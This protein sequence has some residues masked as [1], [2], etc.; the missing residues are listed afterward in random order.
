MQKILDGS[1]ASLAHAFASLARN[2]RRQRRLYLATVVSLMAIVVASALLLALLAANRQLDYRRTLAAQH[3]ADLSLLL[4]REASFLRRTEYTLGF[5]LQTDDVLRLS[6][7]V[8]AS[9]RRSGA[10]RGVVGAE[11]LHFDVLVG[12]ATRA[13]WGPALAAK[14]WRIYEAGQS[15]LVTQ[16]AF[17]LRHRAVLLGLN[18]DYGVILPAAGTPAASASASAS[19]TGTASLPDPA[20]LGILRDSLI[21]QLQT[22]TGRRVPAKGERIWLGP[23]RDPL[24]GKLMMTAV[25]AVYADATPAAPAAPAALIAMS[26]AVDA[27]YAHLARPGSAGTLLLMTT[28][29]RAI[30]ASP[31]T[32]AA[33]ERML[34]D[35]TAS[36][37]GD[38]YRYTRHGVMLLEPLMPGFGWLVGYLPW[39]GLVGV[40]GWQLGALAGV[41]LLMLTAIV[42]TARV[43]GLRLLR[44]SVAETA[45]ALESEALNHILVSATPVGLCIVRQSD[46]ALLIANAL[47]G[48]LLHVSPA[49]AGLPP[50]A[51]PRLSADASSPALNPTSPSL[52]QLP[53]HIVAALRAQPVESHAGSST[54]IAVFVVPARPVPADACSAQF[55]QITYAPARHAGEDVWFCAI[56]DVTAQ[57]ALEQQLRLAQQTSETMLR[58]RS[59]FFASMSH[60]IRTPLN[61]LLGNLELFAR[62]PGL[63]AH[64][65]RLATLGVAADVLRRVVGDI[66]DFS[67]IDAGEMKLVSAPFRVIDDFENLA[68]SYAPLATDRAI[69]FYPHLSPSL[70]QVLCGDRTRIAQIVNNLLGNAFKFTSSG[71]I[72]LHAEIADDLSGRSML[73]CRVSDSG[74]GIDPALVSQVFD[75]FVQGDVNTSSRYGGTGLGLSIC[76][77]LCKLMGGEIAVESALGVGS[78]FSVSIPLAPASGAARMPPVLSTTGG[79]V[80]VLSEDAESGRIM[81]GWLARSGWAV[82]TV[83]SQP[84]AHAWLRANQLDVLVVTGEYDLDAIAALRAIRPVR[85]VWV[86]RTGAHRAAW[87]GDTVLEVS[88]FSHA[89]ILAAVQEAHDGHSES[90][91]VAAPAPAAASSA[92]DPA[93]QGLA[94]LVAEDNPLNQALIAEQLVALGAVPTVVGDGQQ[95]LALI[96]RTSFDVV[97]TDVRMPVMDG[98]RLLAALRARRSDLPVLA[99]SAITDRQPADTWRERGFA[100]YIGKPASLDELAKALSA[101]A[102][103]RAGVAVVPPSPIASGPDDRARYM[104]MLKDHLSA[105]LPRL[106]A[107]VERRDRRALRDWAH[108][109]GGAFL[110][111][112]ETGVA[113]QCREL[114]RLCDAEVR[115]RPGMGKVAMTLHGRLCARFGLDKPL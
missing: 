88:A 15:T 22:Q 52:L 56:L 79:R 78:V 101:V 64:R 90:C 105:D 55:L 36:L 41:A 48:E 108:G 42:V 71:K 113:M 32:D 1:Q 51:Q 23:Y 67:K 110:V 99:F 74:I 92:P 77:R 106:A 97:L 43:W 62:T 85:A 69:R 29:R 100:G 12:A 84:R 18:E 40:L 89:A 63:D 35:A 8:E 24:Q 103:R 94:V 66:L 75:P 25:S 16:Q 80:L 45:R 112:R 31:P 19:A 60:E 27:L 17:E 54:T 111:V 53:P 65:Q 68:L 10:A 93:L 5:Y 76:A 57:H 3:A 26:I 47:A 107:I 7:G 33:T 30:V 95:A 104:A 44:N 38:R 14:L 50:C 86:T 109:A 96:D 11:G 61:A 70:D 20:V 6:D 46:D 49:D 102:T 59:D 4:H 91:A 83:D 82:G 98:D 87:H 13:K 37:S 58:A 34:H 9:I 114:Q 2:A 21:A 81:E 115:W 39:R 28:G 73:R 72:G